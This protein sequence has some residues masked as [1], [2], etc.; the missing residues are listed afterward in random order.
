MQIVR[1]FTYVQDTN[2]R[3]KDPSDIIIMILASFN[4]A[5]AVCQVLT[6]LVFANFYKG[7]WYCY[8]SI[9]VR[10]QRG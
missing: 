6:Y 2:K 1:T 5:H 10:T 3:A 4:R 8:L 9:K 7:K